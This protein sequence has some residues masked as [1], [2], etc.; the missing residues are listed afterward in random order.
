MLLRRLRK[1]VRGREH[2]KDKESPG[3]S[4]RGRIWSVGAW[5]SVSQ[6]AGHDGMSV[7]L[8]SRRARLPIAAAFRP[9]PEVGARTAS[10]VCGFTATNP[11]SHGRYRAAV[12]RSVHW[13]AMTD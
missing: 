3:E 11:A 10:P 4:T 12:R 2:Q 6:S 8:T 5:T 1:D 7:T 13:A 9:M